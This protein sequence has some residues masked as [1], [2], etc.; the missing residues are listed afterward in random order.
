MRKRP[1]SAGRVPDR[2]HPSRRPRGGS[3]APGVLRGLPDRASR[4]GRAARPAAPS[5][6]PDRRG[7]FRFRQAGSQ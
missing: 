1:V 3:T 6:L 5:G 7:G 4:P 2:F